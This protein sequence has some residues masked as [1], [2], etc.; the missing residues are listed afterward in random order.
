MGI[1][2]TQNRVFSTVQDKIEVFGQKF[3]SRAFS[4]KSIEKFI[5][6]FRIWSLNVRGFCV[7]QIAILKY[8]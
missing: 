4:V 1:G 3:I 8:V 6:K 5:N 2:L 7:D